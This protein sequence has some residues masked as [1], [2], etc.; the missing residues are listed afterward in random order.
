MDAFRFSISWA[1]LIPSKLFKFDDYI[2]FLQKIIINFGQLYEL[3]YVV[4]F[5]IIY[6]WKAKGWSKQRR[7]TILQG[8]Y[9]R[10]SC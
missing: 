6:R 3:I 9:R 10:T 7:Y 1:R 2:F 5:S 8:S 4:K